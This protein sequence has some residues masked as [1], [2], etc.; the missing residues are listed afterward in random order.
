MKY[1]KPIKVGLILLLGITF[2][3]IFHRFNPENNIFFPKCPFYLLTGY[4]CPGCGS[5]RAIHHIL[6]LRIYDALKENALLVVS[7]P[8]LA[9]GIVFNNLKSLTPKTLLWRQRLYGVKAI[10]IIIVIIILFWVL[11]NIL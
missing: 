5:Q 6:N 11:R 7:I 2:L 10:N 4:K 1:I 3:I 8:Y 9:T